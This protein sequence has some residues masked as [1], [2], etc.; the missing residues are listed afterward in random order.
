MSS[1][2][3]G[4]SRPAP[5]HIQLRN[6]HRVTSQSIREGSTPNLVMF[7]RHFYSD[8]IEGRCELSIKGCY[9]LCN[10]LLLF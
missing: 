2:E 6:R 3:C 5:G 1:A 10:S 8:D 4:R 7:Y 9:E